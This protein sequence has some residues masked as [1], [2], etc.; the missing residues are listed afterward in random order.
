MTRLGEIIYGRDIGKHQEDTAFI[1]H[2]CIDCGKERWVRLEQG[3]PANLR[4]LVCSNTGE[5]N[6]GYGKIRELSHSWKGGRRKT[7]KGYIIVRL[8]PNDFFYP[9]TT[10][11]SV[12][13]EHRLVMAKHLGRCL[14]P[15]EVIHH[16]NG[17]RDDNRL[18]NLELLPTAKYHVVDTKAKTY[19]KR[20][21]KRITVLEGEVTL[22][23]SQLEKDK[24]NILE[25]NNGR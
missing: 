23:H 20:L 4:C 22:L 2:A 17:V 13:C 3:K 5:R 25:G 12:V 11:A 18:E 8:Y 21:E 1:W 15:W 6:P 19:I 7:D 10:K 24:I 16:R 14:L 9:M